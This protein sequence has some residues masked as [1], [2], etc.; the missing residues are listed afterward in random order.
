[1]RG[2]IA[3][4]AAAIPLSIHYLRKAGW[5]SACPIACQFES[6]LTFVVSP[7]LPRHEKE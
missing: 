4:A 5:Q 2:T 3:D 7:E 6:D 1:M